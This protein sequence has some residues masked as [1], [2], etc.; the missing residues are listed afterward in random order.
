MLATSGCLI[1]NKLRILTTGI[2]SLLIIFISWSASAQTLTANG[3]QAVVVKGGKHH[4]STKKG[5]QAVTVK[6]IAINFKGDGLVTMK[7]TGAGT[8]NRGSMTYAEDGDTTIGACGYYWKPAA[9]GTAALTDPVCYKKGSTP[10]VS[11]QI[12]VA[13]VDASG[14]DLEFK[15][16]GTTATLTVSKHVGASGTVT[17]DLALSGS[18]GGISNTTMTFNWLF[19]RVGAGVWQELNAVITKHRLFVTFDAPGG[20]AL[21]TSN[22]TTA[23]RMDWCTGGGG[24]LSA[25]T[26]KNTLADIGNAIA[27]NAT[28][29][30]RFSSTNS[31]FPPSNM[32]TAWQVMDG[33]MADCSTLSTL[34]CYELDTLGAV[35]AVVRVVCACHQDWSH[36]AQDPVAFDGF[37]TDAG[38]KDL[39]IWF[40]AGGWNYYEGCCVFQGKWWMGGFGASNPSA[41][42]VLKDIW[43]SGPNTTDGLGT[44]HQ[45]YDGN[46]TT[47]ATHVPYPSTIP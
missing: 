15:S 27:P 20:T 31:I 21:T 9:G 41:V 38:G 22:V 33:T 19:R 46:D 1:S 30:G 44:H 11:L 16:S 42:T 29:S 10:I 17:V 23:R 35:G 45:C 2:L 26:G 40:G 24:G 14:I 5:D 12:A 43:V 18:V 47:H 13:N 37:E 6:L 7:K 34:M 3:T 25:I 39:G 32:S 36:L 8:Y 28:G 4:P